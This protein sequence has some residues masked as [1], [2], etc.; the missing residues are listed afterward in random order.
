MWH[1]ST[2]LSRRQ[3]L[4]AITLAIATALSA[5]GSVAA[6]GV[7]GGLSTD[8]VVSNLTETVNQTTETVAEVAAPVT[9]V[10]SQ[11]PA[12]NTASASESN[13]VTEIVEV[14]TEPV[15]ETV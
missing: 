9:E 3:T 4:L 2:R 15:Q 12:E 6:K 11:T 10:V 8:D 7:L 1:R 13:P 14:V 5:D